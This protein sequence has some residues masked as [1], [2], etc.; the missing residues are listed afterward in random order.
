MSFSAFTI[1]L[2]AGS[3]ISCILIYFAWQN[4]NLANPLP[5]TLVML[6]T[7]E[8]SISYALVINHTVMESK[9]FWVN[10]G[11]IGTS[12]IPVAWL[13]FILQYT[14]RQKYLTR[15]NL[16]LLSIIPIITI[17][18][19]WS[20][21][22]H[23]YIWKSVYADASNRFLTF[24]FGAWSWIFIVYSYLL[25]LTGTI[26]LIRTLN[27]LL[28]PDPGQIMT[29]LFGALF[30]LIGN[31]MFVSGIN[32][33]KPMDPTPFT[34]IL[35]GLF[36]YWG[37]HRFRLW[38]VLPLVQST[39]FDNLPDGVLVLNV[40][41]TIVSLNP[42]AKALL[43]GAGVGRPL[44]ELFPAAAE[45][46]EKYREA[47][48][49][50]TIFSTDGQEKRFY[51]WRLST[52]YG[53]DEQVNGRIIT[54]RD[55]TKDQ[56]REH[57]LQILNDI[58][59][60]AV[61]ALDLLDLLQLLADK[62]GELIH[63]DACHIT[64]WDEAS[65]RTIPGAASG[66]FKDIFHS[67]K[68]E[69]GETTMTQSVLKM[70]RAVPIENPFDTPHIS[71]RLADLFPNVKSVLALP[72]IAANEKLG[73][74]LLL[75]N[76][77][78][79]FVADEINRAEQAATQIALAIA[80]IKF[81]DAMKRQID[82]LAVLNDIAVAGAE[83][84]NEDDLISRSTD[85]I[86]TRFY[87]DNFGVY[88][89]DE[90]A[91]ILKSHDSYYRK[92]RIVQPETPL[93][94]GVV[95]Q[96]A[97]TG[98]PLRLGDVTQYPDYWPITPE[99]RSE[100]CVPLRADDKIIGV[101]NTESCEYDAYTVQDEQLLVTIA[102][103]L[104]TA[105]KKIQ[106]LS[107]EQS[108][109]KEAETLREA[110]AVL[111]ST[112]DLNHLLNLIL[113]QLEKV[114]A[115]DSA[116]IFMFQGDYACIMA[117]RGLP[118]NDSAVGQLFPA[119]DDLLAEM[120]RKKKPVFLEDAQEEPAFQG[121][122]DT[123]YTKGWLGVPLIVRDKVLGYLTID[124]RQTGSYGPNEAVLALAFANQAAITIENARLYE[125]EQK[126]RKVAETLRAAHEAFTAK[127]NLPAVLSALLD[128][129]YRLVPYDSAMIL[130]I[131]QNGYV[132]VEAHKGYE[133]WTDGE[134]VGKITFD[135]NQ[136]WSYRT[137]FTTRQGL[138]IAN[139]EQEPNWET[140]PE[141][142]Y[143]KSWLG[144]PLVIGD[145]M[146]GF[147]SVDKA[148]A[149][150]F[151]EEHLQLTETL[152]EQTAVAIQNAILYQDAQRRAEEMETINNVTSALRQ[153]QTV[154]DVLATVL[155]F[156]VKIT[157]GVRGK[158]VLVDPK[159]GGLVAR[160]A[161]PLDEAFIGQRYE[162]HE[163]ISQHVVT[164]GN[165]Y[166]TDDLFS[167]PMAY[168]LPQNREAAGT[169]SS[170]ISLPLY[171]QTR[172][173]GVMHVRVAG[174]R[175]FSH[176][177]IQILTTIA[178]IAGSALDR[179]LLLETLEQ[180]IAQRTHDLSLAYEQLQELDRLK[181][182]FISD[183]SHELRTP[184]TN[185]NL[186]LDLFDQGNPER[187]PHYM[188]IIRKENGRLTRLIEDT[189]SL[190]RLDVERAKIEMVPVNLTEVVEPIVVAHQTRAESSGLSLTTHLSTDL[191]LLLGEPNQLS[192]VAA[193]LVTNAV[194]YTPAGKIEVNT[195]NTADKSSVCLEV[196]DTGMG[197]DS[198]DEKH[199]F[200]RFY[201]GKNTGQSNIPGTGL[202]LTI[203]KEIVI[204]HE[205]Q[206]EIESELGKGTTFRI[207]FPCLAG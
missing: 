127:L 10:M 198:E 59:Q 171:A 83:A 206:I 56:Q 179:A 175:P 114:I 190:S 1:P 138:L 43:G 139:T 49:A 187:R 117:C 82:E 162:A 149:G 67:I 144:V 130:R 78:H 27:K 158:V 193:Q 22:T 183:V 19:T 194:N 16:I 40:Q 136:N 31:V 44:P 46:L 79:H 91:N 41:D 71:K 93:N 105:I 135:A 204:L 165:I 131:N 161:Y 57:Y 51:D 13:I 75:F 76:Q 141:T 195:Y 118:N 122:I 26:L 80:K 5:F 154:D 84:Q 163:S 37:F 207:Y 38:N 106:L 77:P 65:Q 202:G 116:T 188:G 14:Y 7:V 107:L 177:E 205:G 178:E 201:R 180:R 69:S 64:L 87:P 152:T 9:I 181:T 121:W 95:G 164:T 124:S 53:S 186:Y 111:T 68:I 170:C 47:A 90:K 52:I 115:Y 35:A 72:F 18:L 85:I 191:P 143:V 110:T 92:D 86:R 20:N 125:R 15:R 97:A 50:Q 8:W 129:L 74:A 192:Q 73:A 39:L 45:P 159:N 157:A 184:I 62:M 23:H 174:K 11:Y 151:T 132:N 176:D 25:V 128:F 28:T 32:P 6:A 133:K 167:D 48:N 103:Q 140:K 101:I 33:V 169:L 168:V 108:R 102:G 173:I 112:L 3:I 123:N 113:L 156:A 66:V 42:A 34:F 166:M 199:I 189:L 160:G 185:I 17:L 63:A 119:Q 60:A 196:K 88:L 155:A 29:L 197:I 2:F 200:E 4:R 142:S 137:L 99:T 21:D 55:I 36:M 30:P 109:R 147:F 58:T 81:N 12:I 100:L 104:A 203:V 89:V 24:T 120:T 153:V 70:G 96:V 150:F 54:L 148:E 126:E 146:F 98:K 172:I 94:Q 145:G 134:T 61:S 182:K